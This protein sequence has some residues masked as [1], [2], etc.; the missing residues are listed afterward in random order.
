MKAA[1]HRLRSMAD[2]RKDD[3]VML[4]VQA[5]ERYEFV[6]TLAPI[7]FAELFQESLRGKLSFDQIIDREMHD[8]FAQHTCYGKTD[9]TEQEMSLENLTAFAS[10]VAKAEREACAKVCRDR[11]AK[12][13]AETERLITEEPD[14]VT[15]LRSTA[16][17]LTVAENEILKRSNP[18]ERRVRARTSTLKFANV[19]CSQCG[20][21]FGPGD[22]GFSHCEN[23]KGLRPN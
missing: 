15:A 2:G 10:A 14:E 21:E 11:A 3:G 23:H 1:I 7:R 4:V 13:T 8:K 17:Q 6:R 22:H 9:G 18:I 19:F 5:A 16:W 12:I 20:Q